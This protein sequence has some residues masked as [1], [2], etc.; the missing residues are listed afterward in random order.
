MP[1]KKESILAV[2]KED[3]IS[4]GTI[5]A[6]MRT[7]GV[8]PGPW[9]DEEK[10]DLARFLEK[11]LAP[12]AEDVIVYSDIA[13]AFGAIREAELQYREKGTALPAPPQENVISTTRINLK[14]VLETRFLEGGKLQKQELLPDACELLLVEACLE[15]AVFESLNEAQAVH[16]LL[17]KALR[18]SNERTDQCDLENLGRCLALV[19]KQVGVLSIIRPNT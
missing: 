18:A 14:A 8:E 9:S 7:D 2:I 12:T 3:D 11:R 19:A 13:Y 6:L 5:L 16:D 17:L 1:L 15:H 4:L 10:A